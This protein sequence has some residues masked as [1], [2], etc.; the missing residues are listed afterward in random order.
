[1]PEG[2]SFSFFAAPLSVARSGANVALTWPYYPAGYT[3]QSTPSLTTPVTWT[4]VATTPTMSNNQFH[5][6]L[7]PS[8][9][10]QYFRLSAP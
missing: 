9:A 8:A 6:I 3:L 5:V 1:M 2:R 4:T 10:M 7:P